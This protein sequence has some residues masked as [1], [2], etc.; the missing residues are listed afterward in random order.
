MVELPSRIIGTLR[1]QAGVI[2]RQQALEGGLTKSD[3][4]RLVRRREWVRVLPGV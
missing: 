1:D 4:D 2:A 3:I